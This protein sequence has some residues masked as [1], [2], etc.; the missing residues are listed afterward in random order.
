MAQT[1]TLYTIGHSNLTPDNFLA[2]LRRH[3]IAV[4]L[5]IRSAPYS[6]YVPHFNKRELEAFIKAQ[7]LDYRYAGEYLGGRPTDVMLYKNHTLPPHDVDREDFLK[8][9]DYRAVMHSEPYQRGIARLLTILRETIAGQVVIM[10]S[11]GDPLHCHRHH[12]IARSLLDPAV[13]IV[14]ENVK[15]LHIVRDANIEVVDGTHFAP[16]PPQQL[17]LF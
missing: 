13:K 17:S 10:C 7:G 11:E 12:L 2:A 5:D 1:L 15:V 4:L 3:N 14:T 8:Q 9:V 6:R 16:D